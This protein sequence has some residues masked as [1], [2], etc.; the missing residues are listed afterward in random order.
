MTAVTVSL[1]VAVVLVHDDFAA[2]G[3][4]RL[5]TRH[6]A[7]HDLLGGPVVEHH[8][9]RG[10]TLG[11]RAFGMCVV[12]VVARTIREHRVHQMR[13]HLRCKDLA[14]QQTARIVAGLLVEEIP[15]SARFG[16]S[17]ERI[18][19]RRTRA[20][21]IEIGILHHDAVLRLDTADLRNGHAQL[22][23]LVELTTTG[24][25]RSLFVRWLFRRLPRRRV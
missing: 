4:Q 5:R 22:P 23:N 9:G 1:A 11:C 25:D 6:A 15:G 20:H 3:Q 8:F 18:D 17:E 7:T 12:D 14:Q 19:Q 2:V 16:A 10:A 24:I 21:G 13:L